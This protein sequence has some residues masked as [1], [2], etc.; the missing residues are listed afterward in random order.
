MNKDLKRG[1]HENLRF[2]GF[3]VQVDFTSFESTS[4]GVDGT[5]TSSGTSSGVSWRLVLVLVLVVATF[6]TFAALGL[7]ETDGLLDPVLDISDSVLGVSDFLLSPLADTPSLELIVKGTGFED[8]KVT[9]LEVVE[10]I[11]IVPGPGKL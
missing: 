3:E 4:S 2:T 10:G 9:S 6:A 7:L 8:L 1:D 5:F 11:D